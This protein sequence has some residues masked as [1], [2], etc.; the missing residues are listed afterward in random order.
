M[1]FKYKKSLSMLVILVILLS[2]SIIPVSASSDYYES[3]YN[4]Y[5]YDCRSNFGTNELSGEMNYAGPTRINIAIDYSY[6]HSGY[7]TVHTGSAIAFPQTS[8]VGIIAT[9]NID[10]YFTSCNYSYL[11]GANTVYS[12]G[13]F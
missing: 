13:L 9:I 3:T 4:Y 1:K 7:L 5:N 6:M 10:Y 2:Y 12:V 8:F 11:I